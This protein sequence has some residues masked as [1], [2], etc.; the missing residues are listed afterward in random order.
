MA[1]L[2]DLSDL[3]D[4]TY[5]AD[6]VFVHGLNGHWRNTWGSSGGFWPDWIAEDFP[7]AVRSVEYEAA[8]TNWGHSLS[9]PERAR[10]L[11]AILR[12]RGIGERPVVFIAHS[13]GGLI[14]KQLLRYAADAREDSRERQLLQN[15]RGVIF[16]A[17]PHTGSVVAT[18]A[19]L[20]PR[21]FFWQGPALR[22]LKANDPHLIDLNGWY[23]SHS[24][25]HGIRT[26]VFRETKPCLLRGQR[27]VIIVDATASDPGIPDV[28][29]TPT[30][31]DHLTI[32]APLERTKEV[33]VGVGTFLESLL[34]STPVPEDVAPVAQPP[35]G[36]RP[37]P[38]VVAPNPQ[39]APAAQR[40]DADL[41]RRLGTRLSR[42]ELGSLWYA[43]FQTPLDH[44][45][46][47]AELPTI[48]IDL[49]HRA[50]QRRLSE[51]LIERLQADFPHV[52]R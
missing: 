25:R 46:P 51:R 36:P 1:Q 10:N 48:A 21:L 5:Q 32:A 31:E 33:Y 41:A 15:T 13:L 22:A 45:H 27:T 50:G 26:R 23:R 7:A 8:F 6:I 40:T 35:A 16:L 4:R 49:V 14:V 30:D 44:T 19:L 11:E 18:V 42:A 34:R 24:L 9:I 12:D 17:T 52:L 38:A 43:L 3:S 28:V 39:P 29:P 37:A 2:H 47:N 20:L